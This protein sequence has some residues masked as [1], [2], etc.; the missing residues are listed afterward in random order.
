VALS[1]PPV[2]HLLFADDSQLFFIGS[3]EGAEEFSGLLEVYCQSSDQRINRDKSSI[4]FTKSCPWARRDKIKHVLHVESEALN[5]RYLGMPTVVGSSIY[6]TF[7]FFRDRI[8]SKVKGWLEKILS[9]GGKEVLIKSVAQAI[10][11][12]SMAC[13]RLPRGLCDHINSLIR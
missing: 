8:W 3:R 4:F 10:P 2:N 9:A 6:G 11:V 7:K 1:A 13:F 12:F 5:E